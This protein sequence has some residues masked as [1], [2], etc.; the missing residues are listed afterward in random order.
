MKKTMAGLILL[1][2]A[3]FQY[4][5]S[6]CSCQKVPCPGFN[7]SI[8]RAWFPYDDPRVL[9]FSDSQN[10]DTL[11]LPGFQKSEEYEASKGCFNSASGCSASA[12]LYADERIN[13]GYL[14]FSVQLNQV[15]PFETTTKA[16][17]VDFQFYNFRISSVFLRANGLDVDGSTQF[18]TMF[19]PSLM[20]GGKNYEN[21]QMI[22][23][24]TSASERDPG[25]YKIYLS[26]YAGLVGYEE[27]PSLTT[28][29]LQ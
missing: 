3:F 21:V 14:K 16:P 5:C 17:Q 28:F 19:F 18:H 15:T 1:A 4:D 22:T 23:K 27:Y 26:K 10:N 12:S 24:D 29:T 6:V 7:D 20:L 25:P 11:S 2:L 9:V 13:G 8:T